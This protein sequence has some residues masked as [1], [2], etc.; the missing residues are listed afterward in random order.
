MVRMLE[1][2]FTNICLSIIKK[3]YLYILLIYIYI[4][5]EDGCDVIFREEK[6]PQTLVILFFNC[7]VNNNHYIN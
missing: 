3:R 6:Y 4:A 1:H 5:D 2:I 7:F